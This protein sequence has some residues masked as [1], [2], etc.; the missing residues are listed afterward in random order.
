L[1]G[2]PDRGDDFGG[3]SLGEVRMGIVV[4]EK[5]VHGGLA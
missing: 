3:D 5:A 4:V 1:A 2:A